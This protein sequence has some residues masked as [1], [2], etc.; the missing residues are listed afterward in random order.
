MIR[1]K[2]S[3][4]PAKQ[5][6]SAPKVSRQGKLHSLGRI[7]LLTLLARIS[8]PSTTNTP[9]LSN[10][11]TVIRLFLRRNALP[12]EPAMRLLILKVLTSSAAVT[13]VQRTQ[14]LTL[15]RR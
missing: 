9:A 12:T 5:L 14:L 4:L 13:P 1:V 6:Y 3:T 2:A 7:I 15:E 8:T 10:L 11:R